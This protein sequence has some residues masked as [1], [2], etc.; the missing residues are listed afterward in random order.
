[1][2]NTLQRLPLGVQH[3]SVM[4][5]ENMFY[6]D[7]T[8]LIHRLT[9][10]CRVCFLSRPRR[11]GKSLLVTTL[12]AYFRGQKELFT[13]LAMEKL[14][15]EWKQHPVL[16]I[17]FAI[18][19]Y[20]DERHLNEVIGRYLSRWE[21]TYH[22][23]IEG[24]F[25]VRLENVIRS[26]YEQTGLGVVL[27]VDE[28]DAP[29]LDSNGKPELQ[30]RLRDI[31]RDFYSPVKDMGDCLRFVFLTGISKFSQMSIFSELNNLKNISMDDAYSALCGITEEEL[32]TQM[33]PYIAE[34]AE[35]N[36]E[37]YD[38]AVAHLKYQYDGYHFSKHSPDIYNPYSLINALA[39]REYKNYWFDTGTPTF[40][41]ELLQK[42]RMDVLGLE[43]MEVRSTAF[44]RASAQLENPV[45]VLYQSGYLTIKDYD[46]LTRYYTLAYPNEEV[47]VGFH[48]ALLPAYLKQDAVKSDIAMGK[49]LRD[50]SRR[51]V[52]ACL[53]K[54]QAFMASIPYDQ[55]LCCEGN[56]TAFNEK[57]FQT[58]FHILFTL[59]GANYRSEVKSAS[60]RA[61][62]VLELHDAIY[63][64]EFKL[65]GGAEAALRQIGEK[66]YLIPYAADHRPVVKVGVNFDTE[67]RT[68]SEWK[69]G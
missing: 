58:V 59:L 57:H 9:H 24:T 12:E 64:F 61:D 25:S 39:D 63:V 62:A 21:A 32:L 53:T 36:G 67:S 42:E 13:G 29:M 34:L 56:D 46:P 52:D 41:V 40:L 19:K 16:H 69:V 37:T 7:K 45:P 6:A 28:Y 20:T 3:F 54:I 23:A 26:A 10:E 60:G 51:D 14:E 50:L 17:S 4:R 49:M 30:D 38:E 33:Q 11:F 47:R 1:M 5:R 44:D 31:T 55:M 35:A 43:G 2:N 18:S 68:I 65:D 27:L 66:G 48:E 22:C 8:A 15:Q